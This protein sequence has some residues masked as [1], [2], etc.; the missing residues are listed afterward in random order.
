MLRRL[1]SVR[2]HDAGGNVA[3]SV[4]ELPALFAD[5]PRGLRVL[6]IP[7]HR[8]VLKNDVVRRMIRPGD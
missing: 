7:F 8:I 3:R 5:V 4:D 1:Y 2:K 6:A